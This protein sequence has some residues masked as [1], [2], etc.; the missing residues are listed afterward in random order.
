MKINFKGGGGSLVDRRRY[1]MNFIGSVPLRFWTLNQNQTLSFMY[2]LVEKR[3]HSL[4]DLLFNNYDFLVIVA[5]TTLERSFLDTYFCSSWKTRPSTSVP[6]VVLAGL[7]M[8]E[9]NLLLSFLPLMDTKIRAQVWRDSCTLH[10]DRFLWHSIGFCH[11]LH[12]TNKIPA[13]ACRILP[14]NGHQAYNRTY[15][16]IGV[17]CTFLQKQKH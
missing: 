7:Y 14:H 4:L 13:E 2:N 12:Q 17:F 9:H 1:S 15:Y 6:F 10:V 3:T 5:L 11:S 16:Y 8:F